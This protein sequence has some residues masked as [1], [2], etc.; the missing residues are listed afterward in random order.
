M[1]SIACV[2][3]T[4]AIADDLIY[5]HTISDPPM[6]GIHDQ[7]TLVNKTRTPLQGPVV[8]GGLIEISATDGSVTARAAAPVRMINTLDHHLEIKQVTR[9]KTLVIL[10]IVNHQ[11]A[12]TR[13]VH[14]LPQLRPKLLPRQA[15]KAVTDKTVDHKEVGTDIDR[16]LNEWIRDE[17]MTPLTPLTLVVIEIVIGAH[18]GCLVRNREVLGEV[19]QDIN[20]MGRVHIEHVKTPHIILE[21]P[22][23]G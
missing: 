20:A 22:R 17:G 15:R 10:M 21:N 19:T 16:R 4:S 18:K 7:R 8:L 23:L 9:E 5:L 2:R 14:A 11:I 6:V 1:S 12:H 3:Q 13:I